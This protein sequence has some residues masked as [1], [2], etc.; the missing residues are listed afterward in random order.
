MPEEPTVGTLRIS[1]PGST[2]LGR[3]LCLKSGDILE[4]I[5]GRIFRGTEA[6]LE[7]RFREQKQGPMALGFRRGD[8]SFAVL[9]PS[10]RLGYWIE[11]QAPADV[12]E[13]VINPLVLRNWEIL[14]DQNQVYDLQPAS[15]GLLA[16]IAPPFWL[17][18][19][20][21]WI[22]GAALLAAAMVA[23]SV[24]PI[25]FT[26]VY[27]ASG[28]HIWHAGPRYFR[29]DRKARGMAPLMVLAAPSE[30]AA[31]LALHKIHPS[32]IFAFSVQTENS[33]SSE[34][35]ANDQI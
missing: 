25:M 30:K 32:A 35:K 19:M 5:N 13:N 1:E 24:S 9:A 22:P 17:L 18:Q 4:T 31:H 34:T 11:T 8:K 2:I 16:L 21:L 23:V 33:E 15:P 28:L 7:K 27:L 26:A 14:A 3:D 20:R 10:H 6:D 29:K 12:A